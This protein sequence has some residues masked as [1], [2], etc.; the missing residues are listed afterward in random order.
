VSS[1]PNLRRAKPDLTRFTETTRGSSWRAP[2][3]FCNSAFIFAAAAVHCRANNL[4]EEDD[5]PRAR[6]VAVP[7]IPFL[8]RQGLVARTSMA[9][10]RVPLLVKVSN[11][12][13]RQQ[14][15]HGSTM[16]AEGRGFRHLSSLCQG[17]IL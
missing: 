14:S 2:V 7:W 3:T 8:G 17:Q 11:S 10:E 1:K 13:R 15:F 5:C 12:S 16:E 4:E 9:A 6:P